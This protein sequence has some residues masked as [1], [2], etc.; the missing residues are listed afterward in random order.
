MHILLTNYHL[1]AANKTHTQKPLSLHKK[2]WRIFWKKSLK[3]WPVGREKE[4]ENREE[5]AMGV[6]RRTREEIVTW[7]QKTALRFQTGRETD[8]SSLPSGMFPQENVVVYPM[9]PCKAK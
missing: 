2:Y 5:R 8:I 3:N 1:L 4:R 6:G 9:N 7:N